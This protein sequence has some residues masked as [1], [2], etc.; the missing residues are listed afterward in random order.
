MGN[1]VSPMSSPRRGH[2]RGE[3]DNLPSASP[4][5]GKKKSKSEK[6]TASLPTSSMD[7]CVVFR[8]NHTHCVISDVHL[9]HKKLKKLMRQVDSMGDN[10]NT[11]DIRCLEFIDC[12]LGL[13]HHDRFTAQLGSFLEHHAPRL[14]TFTVTGN[15]LLETNAQACQLLKLLPEASLQRLR[16]CVG[17]TA[18]VNLGEALADLMVHS[19]LN[20]VVLQGISW[21]KD[22]AILALAQGIAQSNSLQ[23]L[24]LTNCRIQDSGFQAFVNT[25]AKQEPESSTALPLKS[26]NLKDNHLTS[27]AIPDLATLIQSCTNLRKLVINGMPLLFDEATED[28]VDLFLNALQ[29]APALQELYM[30]STGLN[31]DFLER[32]L[33]ILPNTNLRVLNLDFNSFSQTCAMQTVTPH[34]PHLP[35]CLESLSLLS[36][37]DDNTAFMFC[38]EDDAGQAFVG[39]EQYVDS[40]GSFSFHDTTSSPVPKSYER[41]L[42]E[43]SLASLT[44]DEDEFLEALSQTTHLYH[45]RLVTD[46]RSNHDRYL[47]KRMQAVVQRNQLEKGLTQATDVATS[48]WTY[49]MAKTTASSPSVA[50]QPSIIFQVLQ[51]YGAQMVQN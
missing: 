5:G 12:H 28:H 25:L 49:H 2:K 23:R 48:V 7:T 35:K 31:E 33:H 42:S 19:N 1:A 29:E 32:L 11:R 9:E 14:E 3:C 15:M 36:A 10:N 39:D 21:R 45:L 13:D 4:R 16:F 20:Q 37:R 43:S 44:N 8:K 27:A 26:I 41:K 46:R 51:R 50:H 40:Y 38:A 17:Q 34:L 22:A 30:A 18:N 6:S 24:N 47:D